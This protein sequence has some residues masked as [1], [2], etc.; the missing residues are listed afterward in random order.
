MVT[1]VEERRR[2]S[3]SCKVGEDQEILSQS[4]DVEHA[5]CGVK[6]RGFIGDSSGARD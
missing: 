5:E 2:A 3:P 4:E 1:A 6:T